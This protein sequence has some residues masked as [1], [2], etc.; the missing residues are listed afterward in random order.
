MIDDVESRPQALL[1]WRHIE[2][3]LTRAQFAT[4]G[5]I[6]DEA[7]EKRHYLLN[8]GSLTSFTKPLTKFV[9]FY[10]SVQYTDISTKIRYCAILL[11]RCFVCWK[12]ARY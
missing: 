11:H 12:R 4:S 5:D 10:L 6:A 8:I 9:C 7:S 2:A 3:L 1:A